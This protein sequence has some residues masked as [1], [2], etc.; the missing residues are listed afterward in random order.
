MVSKNIYQTFK[1][2]KERIKRI[3][4]RKSYDAKEKAKLNEIKDTE[5]LIR[6]L[7]LRKEQQLKEY[8]E[9][10]D[11]KFQKLSIIYNDSSVIKN[12][13]FYA[14]HT[15]FSRSILCEIK[16]ICSQGVNVDDV[17]L[18]LIEKISSADIQINKEIRH[19]NFWGDLLDVFGSDLK[20]PSEEDT[21]DGN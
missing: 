4:I 12:V 3:K 17:D 16:N 11:D 8:N 19:T 15:T 1:E 7:N 20:F 18:D 6:E 14:E 13:V 21:P 10:R 5:D 9:I 2:F